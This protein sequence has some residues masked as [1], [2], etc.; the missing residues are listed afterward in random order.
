MRPRMRAEK[1]TLSEDVEAEAEPLTHMGAPLAALDDFKDAVPDGAGSDGDEGEQLDEDFVSRFHFGG[2]GVAVEGGAR[3][4]KRDVMAEVMARS[5][6]AKAEKRQQKDDDE[7]L[8][9]RLDERFAALQHVRTLSSYI[10][11]S[12]TR[13]DTPSARACGVSVRRQE[14]GTQTCV[15][16]CRC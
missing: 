9:S 14:V 6:H 16:S 8:R 7:E 4:S 11:R 15:G 1:F 3:K 2:G 12:R 10:S 13:L 5:K